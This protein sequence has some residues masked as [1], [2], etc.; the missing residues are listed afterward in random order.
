MAFEQEGYGAVSPEEALLV[1]EAIADRLDAFGVISARIEAELYG[2]EYEEKPES[3]RRA[4]HLGRT[5]LMLAKIESPKLALT[6]SEYAMS[7]GEGAIFEDQARILGEHAGVEVSAETV[8]GFSKII[9][10]D[11]EANSGMDGDERAKLFSDEL[12][13]CK[14]M[15][16]K[17]G[18]PLEEV[19]RTDT[20]YYEACRLSMSPGDAADTSIRLINAPTEQT[21]IRLAAHMLDTM[22]PKEIL[23]RITTDEK[24]TMCMD[25]QFDPEIAAELRRE[26]ALMQ[27]KTRQILFYDF[28]VTYGY[29]SIYEVL[30]SEQRDGLLPKMS[31]TRPLVDAVHEAA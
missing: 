3:L 16:A 28:L 7:F 9:A 13:A 20:Y 31:L 19:Y 21:F 6:M 30:T 8:S 18:V 1:A 4:Y 25:L 17:Y 14:E 24:E 12:E 22:L 11:V 29:D 26:V 5:T 27:E 23:D 10:E 2:V 15:A